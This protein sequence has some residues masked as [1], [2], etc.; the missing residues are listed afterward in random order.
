MYA[1]YSRT[2]YVS[3][4]PQV[5]ALRRLQYCTARL[6]VFPGCCDRSRVWI[7]KTLN[8]YSLMYL[9]LSMAGL[10]LIQH[11]HCLCHNQTNP[12]MVAANA[13]KHKNIA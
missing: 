2:L 8:T 10:V 4:K 9:V 7:E 6:F 12:L 3:R 1:T 11:G 5:L 13:M